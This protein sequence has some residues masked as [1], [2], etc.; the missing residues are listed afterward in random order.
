MSSTFA[1]IRRSER[2][3]TLI[4]LIIVVAI[5][6]IVATIAVPSFQQTLANSRVTEETNRL[7][8][9]LQLARSEAI[10]L[11]APVT[12]C[13]RPPSGSDVCWSAASPRDW[14]NGWVVYQGDGFNA[15]PAADDQIAI[16]PSVNTTI[17]VEA[18]GSF[19]RF[20]RFNPPEGIPNTNGSFFI[21]NET[22]KTA[23][24]I[25]IFNSGRIRT[26]RLTEAEYP[27]DC[28]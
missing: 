3:L 2:G 23:R 14:S 12:V 1:P 26:E 16:D 13:K 5:I 15:N 19:P 20:I 25:V 10:K 8:T 18:N 22:F 17:Q 24:S 9:A 4:E 6:A 27:S 7:V 21:C 11:G 28:I